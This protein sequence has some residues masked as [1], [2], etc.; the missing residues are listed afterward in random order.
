M[1]FFRSKRCQFTGFLN[2]NFLSEKKDENEKKMFERYFFGLKKK[3][4]LKMFFVR[5]CLSKI[6]LLCVE[7]DVANN[8]RTI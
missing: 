2:E 3:E 4:I 8:Y 6:S 5:K 1:I 7:G